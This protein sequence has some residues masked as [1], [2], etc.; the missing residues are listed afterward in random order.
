MKKLIISLLFLL[1]GVSAIA[2]DNSKSEVRKGW[3]FYDDPAP[4]ATPEPIQ[5]QKPQA[6]APQE[7]EAKSVN[8]CLKK[9]TWTVACGFIDPDGD[10][11][12]QAK[13]R[14]ELMK[15]ASMAKNDPKPVAELQRY[16]NWVVGQA[17]KIANM[18]YYN[19]LNNED[20]NDNQQVSSLGISITKDYDKQ[21]SKAVFEDIKEKGSL[22]F[23]S[24]S[25]CSFCHEMA[26]T[27]IRYIETQFNIKV[28]NVP[29]DNVCILA[30]CEKSKDPQMLAEVFQVDTVPSIYLWMKPDAIIKVSNTYESGQALEE[31]ITQFFMMYRNALAKNFQ[32][33]DPNNP[34]V[35]LDFN[36][37][38]NNYG[39]K[40]I[41]L[42]NVK[43]LMKQTK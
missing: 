23:F 40:T 11:D 43:E 3:F 31:R 9:E 16:V 36:E 24:S 6:K 32:P 20:L 38:K 18:W 8:K 19:G 4:V 27:S 41:E 1:S 26:K 13:Q 29:L 37:D 34:N 15:S 42:G 17:T 12:F 39:R 10:F 35:M 28:V 7:Q 21:K 5:P 33:D 2:N 25:D 30:T 22:I 14:D